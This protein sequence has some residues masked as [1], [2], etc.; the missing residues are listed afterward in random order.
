ML[1][2]KYLIKFN[3]WGNKEGNQQIFIISLSIVI[4]IFTRIAA[5]LLLAIAFLKVISTSLT[6]ES[7]G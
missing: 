1:T 2:N 3:T 5:A 6:I 4:G 7:G